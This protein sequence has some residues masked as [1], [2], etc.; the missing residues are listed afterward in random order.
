MILIHLYKLLNINH[1]RLQIIR[2]KN[3][4]PE[5]GGARNTCALLLLLLL[6]SLYANELLLLYTFKLLKS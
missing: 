3:K 6:E 5:L 2:H 1:R 4:F